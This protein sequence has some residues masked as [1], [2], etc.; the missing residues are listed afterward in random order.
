MC[1]KDKPVPVCRLCGGDLPPQKPGPGAR[2]TFCKPCGIAR[3]KEGHRKA[4]EKQARAAGVAKVKGTEADC[5][6]CGAKYIRGGIRTKYCDP[7]KVESQLERARKASRQKL[8]EK[9]ARKIGSKDHCKHCGVAYITTGS[10]SCYCDRCKLL[11]KQSKLPYLVEHS[12]AYHAKWNAAR[13][14][15]AKTDPDF[16]EKLVES[17]RRSRE[18]RARDPRFRITERMSAGVRESLRNGKNGRRW[19]HLVGY[20][21]DELAAHLERQ[22]LPGMSWQNMG[23]WH[24]DHIVPKVAFE[25]T[26]A[27]DPEFARCWSLP[28]LRPLWGGD[29]MRKNHARLHLI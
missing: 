25:F 14:E 18:K 2:F 21:R 6:R 4:S 23:E 17:R 8:L 7:C 9:G 27:S 15:R 16:R 13:L 20:T 1:A 24:I 3:R 22:F 11:C 19:E 5:H 28:N 10:R 12:R 26:D 29:N